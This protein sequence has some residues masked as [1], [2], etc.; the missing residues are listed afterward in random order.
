M[1]GSFKQESLLNIYFS[2]EHIYDEFEAFQNSLLSQVLR[3]CGHLLIKDSVDSIT[4]KP[5]IRINF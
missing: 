4:Q 2:N 1:I 5:D 3:T